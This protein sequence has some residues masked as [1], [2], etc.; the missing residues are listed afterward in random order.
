MGKKVVLPP[1]LIA[2]MHDL[3]LLGNDAAHVEARVFDKI[4][5]E[6]VDLAID[7]TKEVLKGVYQLSSIVARLKAFAKPKEADG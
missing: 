7:I 2:G 6:E 3:R 4:G 5:K 1:D